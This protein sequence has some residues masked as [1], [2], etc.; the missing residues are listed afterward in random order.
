MAWSDPENQSFFTT[1]WQ[2]FLAGVFATL[3]A[4]YVAVTAT[5]LGRALAYAVSIGGDLLI[6]MAL[7]VWLAK[8]YEKLRSKNSKL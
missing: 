1:G 2:L 5:G 7:F 6:L 4:S 8:A 3:G